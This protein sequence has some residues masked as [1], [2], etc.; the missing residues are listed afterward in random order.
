MSAWVPLLSIPIEWAALALLVVACLYWERAG[1]SGLGVEGAFASGM[2]GLALGYEWTSSY[3]LALL[4]AAGFAAAFALAAGGLLRAFRTDTAIGALALSLVPVCALQ[5]LYR[6]GL[7]ITEGT[8]PPGLIRGTDLDGTYAEDLAMNPVLWA[9]P[10]VVALAGWTLRH[11]PFGLRVRAFGENP[12]WR[13]PGSRPALYRFG[14]IV[15]GALWTVPAAALLA[16]THLESPPLALGILALACVIASRWSVLGGVLLAA[17]PAIARS[18]RPYAGD[19]PGW[20]I[21]LEILP[22]LLGLSYLALL[23]RRAL[24][25][26]FAPRAGTDPDLL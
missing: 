1:F 14:A 20:A 22:Y 6:S 13:V 19:H 18:C 16:R 4:V 7:A 11:T 26:S 15:L 3:P 12:A 24:R 2:V 10:F 5:I 21:A 8:P 9:A 25:V 17:G 23:S